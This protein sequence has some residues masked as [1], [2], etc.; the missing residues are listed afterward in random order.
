M[1]NKKQLAVNTLRALSIDQIDEANSGHPG[2]LGAAPMAWALW[3]GAQFERTDR[4]WP[5]SRIA[6]F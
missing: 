6:L 3:S 4:N 5:K 2:T 1:Q